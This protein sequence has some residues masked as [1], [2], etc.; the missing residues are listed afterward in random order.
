MRTLYAERQGTLVK[1]AT[2]ELAGQVD[3]R[4]VDA[5]THLIGWLPQGANDREFAR[6]ATAQG[7]E[8]MP[9]SSY[10]IEAR[11]RGGL[12]LGFA[13]LNARQIW[14]GVRRLATAYRG[15]GP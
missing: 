12:V 11:P 2:R 5:G 15:C 6:R 7:V 3:V 14:D 10:C 8:A 13:A 1:A 4:P 9:L